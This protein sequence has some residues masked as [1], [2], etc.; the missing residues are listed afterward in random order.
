MVKNAMKWLFLLLVL[1]VL[2]CILGG[3]ARKSIT[4]S[5]CLEI[6]E[7]EFIKRYGVKVINQRPWRIETQNDSWIVKGSY[8]HDSGHKKRFGGVAVIEI[9]KKTGQIIRCSHGK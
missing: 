7:K 5:E 3:V 2:I 9:R 6:A 8:R 1:L 4:E